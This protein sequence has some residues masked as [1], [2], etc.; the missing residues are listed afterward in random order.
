[1]KQTC[2]IHSLGYY[3]EVLLQALPFCFKVQ[4]VIY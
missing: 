3:T 2:I 4:W 1:M